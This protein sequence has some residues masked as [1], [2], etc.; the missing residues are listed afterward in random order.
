MF[1]KETNG[2]FYLSIDL[3]KAKLYTTND[4]KQ[5]QL[6]E[7]YY[8]NLKERIKVKKGHQEE[9]DKLILKFI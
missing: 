6:E 2:K 1:I 7:E 5:K 9:A 4:K 3:K 8:K